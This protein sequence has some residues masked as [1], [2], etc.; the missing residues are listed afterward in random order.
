MFVHPDPFSALPTAPGPVCKFCSPEPIFGVTE[1][2]MSIF[3]ILALPDLFSAV[4]SALSLVFRFCTPEPI[5]DSTE[6]GV[7]SF[8]VLRSRTRFQLYRARRAHFSCFALQHPFLA[9]SRA[10][11]NFHVLFSRT[12]FRQYQ[13]RRVYF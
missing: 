12:H 5:F 13:A 6:D 3:H 11:A 7:C 1:G 8:H 4:P 10:E 9:L 2:V